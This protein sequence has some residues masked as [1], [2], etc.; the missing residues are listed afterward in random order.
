MIAA[1]A[2]FIFLF[3]CMVF[4]KGRWRWALLAAIILIWM[5]V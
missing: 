2:G 3:M 5:L 4:A 1:M